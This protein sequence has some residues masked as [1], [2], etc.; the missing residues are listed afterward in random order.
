MLSK[1]DPKK[2]KTELEIKCRGKNDSL[3][4]FYWVCIFKI[5]TSRNLC[6]VPYEYNLD[7]SLSLKKVK[8][9]LI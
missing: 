7:L 6:L 1:Y 3:I 8:M 2:I 9:Q 5:T 4:L